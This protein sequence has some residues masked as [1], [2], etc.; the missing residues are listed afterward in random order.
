MI[1]LLW[2]F[3]NIHIAKIFHTDLSQLAV[4]LMQLITLTDVS[5]CYSR[6]VKYPLNEPVP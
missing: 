1:F 2:F 3:V 6:T 4:C 5:Q